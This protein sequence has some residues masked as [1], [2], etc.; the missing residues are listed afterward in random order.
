MINNLIEYFKDKNI[1]ILGFGREGRS[2]YNFIRKYYKDKLITISDMN[3]D[4][5][6]DEVIK[7]DPNIK[8]VTD[9]Y[10]EEIY[11]GYNCIL[12]SPGIVLKDYDL[13]NIYDYIV[14]E[15]ELFLMYFEGLTIGIT[16]TKGKSTTSSLIYKVISEQKDNV[17]F[18]GN[19][20]IPVFDQIEEMNKDS[21]VVL[22]M[23]VHQLQFMDKSPNISIILN[24]FPEHLD[25]YKDYDD[26]MECKCNIFKHQTKKDYFIY[27]IDNEDLVNK[28][29]QHPT[30]AT[31]YEITIKENEKYNRL[32]LVGNKVYLDNELLYEDNN[33]RELLGKH[34]LNNI[35]FVLAVS[36]IL[37]LDNTKTIESINAFQGLEHRLE[38][39]GTYNDITYYND[40]I[41][42]IPEACILALETLG[43]VNTLL[44]GGMERDIDYSKLID[45][46][47]N[48]GELNV[49]CMP[50]TGYRIAKDLTS[51][52]L[53]VVEVKDLDEAVKVSK[54]IT[55]KK[56]ICLLSPAAA[57][58]GFFKNFE[59]RGNKFKE[60]VKS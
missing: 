23:G 57:S 38:K 44:L 17:L 53:N 26:Y 27:N 19:I 31:N 15:M 59:E 54:E 11:N 36:K 10:L 60:L 56:T 37:N 28:V 21:I 9:N 45:F 47:N 22:E 29:K 48:Y 24:M 33:E 25:H 12:K 58:Y 55:K 51:D 2:S 20:G 4:L 14:S 46:L 8:L 3:K 34:N 43:N 41:C 52:K 49:I 40:S 32:S 6:N 35:M 50:E 16:G 5:I 18:L 13:T 39:V 1:L 42:T 30:E 7:N